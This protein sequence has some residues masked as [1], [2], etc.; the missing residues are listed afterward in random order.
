MNE[1]NNPSNDTVV[2][3]GE[4]AVETGVE[5]VAD[6]SG[7][8][9]TLSLR[10]IEEATGRKFATL[11]DALKSL[12]ETYS[13]V[14]KAGQAEK[15][16]KKV[17]AAFQAKDISELE[18]KVGKTTQTSSQTPS[19]DSALKFKIE[20]LAFLVEHPE[21]KDHL[22]FLTKLAKADG[23]SLEE[24]YKSNVFQEFLKAKNIADKVTKEN[25][26]LQNNKRLGVSSD[27]IK[28]LIDEVQKNPTDVNRRQLVKEYL[29]L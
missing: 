26:T 11:D 29:G 5:N 28:R 19:E 22:E 1:V 27:K 21:A 23:V 15:A 3:A 7:G 8:E 20:K 2:S 13:Y 9:T 16:L 25:N 6:S 17:L 4:D 10:K 24:A 18:A 12:K 14:G